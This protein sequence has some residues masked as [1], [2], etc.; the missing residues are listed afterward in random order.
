L[1]T[2]I[3][4]TIEI[5]EIIPRVI[6]TPPKNSQLNLWIITPNFILIPTLYELEAL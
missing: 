2:V 1:E 4:R 3:H 5:M 6:P